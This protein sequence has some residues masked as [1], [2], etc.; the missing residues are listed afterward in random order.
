MT[1]HEHSLLDDPT[2]EENIIPP[3]SSIEVEGVAISTPPPPPS[4]DPVQQLYDDYGGHLDTE[5]N[6]TMHIAP[7]DIHQHVAPEHQPLV[8]EAGQGGAVV[9]LLVGGPLGCALV[10]FG[11]AYANFIKYETLLVV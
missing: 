5:H 8:H 7:L 1:V 10:G 2:K 11:A 4:P 9:G 6:A 3:S